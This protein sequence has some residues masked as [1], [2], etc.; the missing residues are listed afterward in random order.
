MYKKQYSDSFHSVDHQRFVRV[1]YNGQPL[2]LEQCTGKTMCPISSFYDHMMT[3]LYTGD[4]K[5]ACYRK[6][7][8]LHHHKIHSILVQQASSQETS[9][10]SIDDNDIFDDDGQDADYPTDYI[11]E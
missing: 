6:P 5:K 1:M 10:I 2:E 3:Q 4:L 7:K 11:L 9:S 8:N